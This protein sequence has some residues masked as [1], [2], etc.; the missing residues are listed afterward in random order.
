MDRYYISSTLNWTSSSV[1]THYG[2]T[3]DLHHSLMHFYSSKVDKLFPL[4]FQF[5]PQF[6]L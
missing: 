4:S 6:V 2:D 3:L 5:P 1:L